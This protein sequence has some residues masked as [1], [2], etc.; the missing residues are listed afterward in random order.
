MRFI[1]VRK[2]QLDRL[3]NVLNDP[4]KVIKKE[5]IIYLLVNDNQI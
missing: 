4:L 2:K 5:R 3:R 1:E